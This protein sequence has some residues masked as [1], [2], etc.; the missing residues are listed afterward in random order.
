MSTD[1][2]LSEVE[3]EQYDLISSAAEELV[4]GYE[5]GYWILVTK[6]RR[7]EVGLSASRFTQIKL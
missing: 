3:A 7:L 6:S 4:D 1:R 5:P 2:S